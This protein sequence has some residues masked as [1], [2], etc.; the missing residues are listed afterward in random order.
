MACNGWQ[1]S[2]LWGDSS[3]SSAPGSSGEES[4][5]DVLALGAGVCWA[6]SAVI[7]RVLHARHQV[8]ILSFTAWQ[9]L[10]GSLPV[11]LIA[12]LVT[13]RSPVWSSSFVG[14][15]LY[16]ILLST[17]LAY[18]LWVFVLR[19]LPASIAGLGTLLTPV[20]GLAS[21]RLQLGER[22]AVWEGIGMLFIIAAL[23]VLT[24]RELFRR[25]PGSR[26]DSTPRL[27]ASREPDRLV[28][29]VQEAPREASGSSSPA[30]LDE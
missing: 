26:A 2:L 23:A 16:Q 19:V 30:G 12:G 27:G 7:A 6:A 22:V 29:A 13:T 20:V 15:L 5:G 10:L 9:M 17:A 24:G 11:V 18:Y 1:L 4:G 25:Q 28:A 21:A 3:L 8:D 14:A